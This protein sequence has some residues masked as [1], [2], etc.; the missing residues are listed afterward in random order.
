MDGRTCGFHPLQ[1]GCVNVLCTYGFFTLH[2]RLLWRVLP[3]CTYCV[4]K[5]CITAIRVVCLR[6]CQRVH[7]GCSAFCMGSVSAGTRAAQ[8][9]QHWRLKY[10]PQFLVLWPWQLCVVWQRQSAVLAYRPGQVFARLASSTH[11]R[12]CCFL[13]QVYTVQA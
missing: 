5:L 6:V 4:G 11:H 8:H 13:Q 7:I 1:N 3:G 10:L 12:L 9:P 2:G